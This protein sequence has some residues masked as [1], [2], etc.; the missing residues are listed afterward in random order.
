MNFSDVATDIGTQM[1]EVVAYILS[2][3]IDP[4]EK[5]TRLIKAFGIVGNEFY[6]KMFVDNSELF[7]SLAIRS[8]GYTDPEDQIERLA[9]KLV[10]N[11]NL[12]RGNGAIVK[13]FFDSVLGDAQNEAFRNGK[14]MGKVPT[15]TRQLVGETCRWCVARAGTFTNPSGEMFARHDNCDCLLIVKGYNSRNGILTNYR[16]AKR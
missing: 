11:Y 1:E 3:N 12:G 2:L 13:E 8:A 16:K 5:R 14:A 15:L 4:E 7:G 10:Q 9:S 6:S